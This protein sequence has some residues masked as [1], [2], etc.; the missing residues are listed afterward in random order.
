SLLQPIN[1]V[2]LSARREPHSDREARRS[3]APDADAAWRLRHPASPPMSQPRITTERMKNMP[4]SST[5]GDRSMPPRSGMYRRIGRSNGSVTALSA[6]QTD[7]TN[8]LY[9]LITLNAISH[10][11]TTAAMTTHV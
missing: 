7:L 6:C 3:L 11:N 8:W 5:T 2:S 9:G 1:A 4:S 10:E